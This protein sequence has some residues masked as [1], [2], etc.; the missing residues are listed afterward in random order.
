M[1]DHIATSLLESAIL[2]P[3]AL[4]KESL[5]R[6]RSHLDGCALCREQFESLSRMYQGVE[7][8]L[9]SPP[10]ERD[11]HAAGR[12]LPRGLVKRTPEDRRILPEF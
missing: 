1:T 11:R 6:I 4:G 12:I 7:E 9:K 8:A 10:T 2:S 3:D 5:A